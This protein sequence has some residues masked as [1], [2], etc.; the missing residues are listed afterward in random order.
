M[1]RLVAICANGPRQQ[2]KLMPLSRNWFAL[3]NDTFKDA[4]TSVRTAMI[5]LEKEMA[6]A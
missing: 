2:A 1:T 3:P 4:G 5:V 6:L